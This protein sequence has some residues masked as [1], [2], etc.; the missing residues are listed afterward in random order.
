MD[1]NIPPSSNTPDAPD[2]ETM[3]Q[4]RRR[5]LE[6]LSGPPQA[7]KENNGTDTSKAA[8]EPSTAQP[9]QPSEGNQDAAPKVQINIKPAASSTEPS[10][11]NPFSKVISPAAN[12]DGSATDSLAKRPRPESDAQN[13][14]RPA[15]K[16]ASAVT[17]EPVEVFE[18]RTL[19][20]I[21][22]VTLDPNESVDA[23]NH[24]LIFLPNLKQ[25]LEEAN[26]PIRLSVSN[27]DT[28]IVEA[29]STIPQKRSVLEYLLP[30]WKRAIKTIK[31]IRSHTTAK[32]AVLKEAKRLCMSNCIFAVTV[33][34][35]FGR[36]PNPSTDNLAPYLLVDDTEDRGICRDF[37][38]EAVSRFD[39]DDTVKPL[40][41]K[42]FVTISQQLSNM[43]MNDNYKPYIN[44]LK[45]YSMFPRLVTAIAE[46]ALFQM[47]TSAARIE[48]DTLLGP[49][50]RISPLQP[51]VTKEYFVGPKTMDKRHIHTSQ[52]ALRLTLQAHQRDLLDIINHFVR[53]SPTAKART[54]DW[55]AY[56]VNQNHKRRAMHVDPRQVSSDGFMMNVTVV[57]DGLCEPF[58]DSTFSK[59]SRVEI[60]YFRREPRVDIKDETK[61]NADQSSSEKYYEQ[62]DSGVS[63]FISEVFFLNLAAHHYGSEATNAMLKNLDRDIKHI[64]KQMAEL[65]AERQK[66]IN[67]NPAQLAIFDANVKRYNE[68]LEKSMSFKFAVEGVL[69]DKQMQTKSL[70]FMR[71]VTVWLLR[72]ATQTDY[73]PDKTVKLPLPAE[74]PDAFKYLPE[75]VLE[76]IISNFSFILRF[77][78]DVMISA[79]GD[80]II[81][82][83]ITFLTNTEYIKNPYLKARLVTLLFQGTWPVYH[84]TKGVL[85]DALMGT[86][87]ANDYL[88]HALMKFY[89]E[90]ESTGQDRQFYDK[91]NIR[92]EI[93]QVVKCIWPNDVYKQRLTQESKGNTEFFVRFVNLLLNDATYL[94]DE[95]LTKFVKIH[96]LQVELL[97]PPSDM[98][99]E[100]KA[101]KEDALRAAE[102]DAQAYMQ[103]TNETIAMMKLF[104]GALSEAFT[105]PEVVGRLAAMINYTLDTLVGPKSTNLKVHDPS[106]YHFNPKQLLS[107][108]IDIY[109]N[110]GDSDR[111]VT[112]VAQDGRSY[113]PANFDTATKILTRH[114][115]KSGEDI[116]K[117]EALKERVK[118]AKE[119]EDQAE[120]DLG[121]I[122]DEYL[123]P[124]LATLM[125]DPVILP[126]SRITVDRSTIRSHLLSDPHDPFNRQPMKIEDVIEN[127]EL[128]EEIMRWKEAKKLEAQK[129]KEVS[130]DNMEGVEQN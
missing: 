78:P 122:P 31:G 87:F 63:N 33:P 74:E 107:E 23:S 98:T 70:L 56:I 112:A 84:R 54:L 89:I 21:F 5:R 29:A 68:V 126:K 75:Y 72:I 85:G 93:F 10:S 128:K 3:D 80:E 32:D 47:A 12:A 69:L 22:R 96:D 61:L 2:K 57:L 41:M 51:E 45:S 15:P 16:K 67:Q 30:C 103:L 82:L 77:I 9:P 65:E 100:Q 104:T 110:L 52:E 44:A 34:E 43:T 108:F 58:M 11:E 71:Y 124:I 106:K 92:Y 50:F 38:E 73:T 81:T 40:L 39:E 95:A 97:R 94:L 46:D 99:A 101:Q 116:S 127:T 55:F 28:A 26:E 6:K 20:N 13:T 7:V 109:L 48:K 59:I 105:T 83:S 53:A 36:E 62:K 60:E 86:K 79:I 125:L 121:E 90:V 129:A 19:R 118:V 1:N 4:I 113:K 91:F 66:V 49:F 114:S 42:A 27:L 35:L 102:G 123:D 88:L 130:V 14:Q 18:D 8:S 111:F 115:L 37:L 119:A 64:Q 120:E 76:D 17:E 24:R 117:W 25:D